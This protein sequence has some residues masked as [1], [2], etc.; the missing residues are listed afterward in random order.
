MA[1]NSI[2]DRIK[3]TKTGKLI[4]RKMGLGHFRAKKSRKQ[5]R[6]KEGQTLINKFDRK[7]FI[8]KYGLTSR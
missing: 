6:R 5:L 3:V 7:V 2:T 1:K 8:K 4:R